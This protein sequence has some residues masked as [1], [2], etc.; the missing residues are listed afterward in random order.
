M[1][2]KVNKS[3]T[4]SKEVIS[5]LSDFKGAGTFDNALEYLLN[6]HEE[7]EAKAKGETK[8]KLFVNKAIRTNEQMKLTVANVRN[9]TGC[10]AA[11]VKIVFEELKDIINSHNNKL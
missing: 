3:Y 1:S 6:L 7:I 4:L 8:V 9:L 11:A 2:K 5:R 10:R